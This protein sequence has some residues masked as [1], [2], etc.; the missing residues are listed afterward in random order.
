[1]DQSKVYTKDVV[2]NEKLGLH[3]CQFRSTLCRGKTKS[4]NLLVANVFCWWTICVGSCFHVIQ[5]FNRKSLIFIIKLWN[6]CSIA[7]CLQAKSIITQNLKRKEAESETNKW[8]ALTSFQLHYWMIYGFPWW[9]IS[10]ICSK[11]KQNGNPT[12]PIIFAKCWVRICKIYLLILFCIFPLAVY[13]FKHSIVHTKELRKQTNWFHDQ[14]CLKCIFLNCTHV[15][16]IVHVH[17]S[18]PYKTT[19]IWRKKIRPNNYPSFLWNCYRKHNI[20]FVWPNTCGYQLS[21][22]WDSW[23]W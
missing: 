19:C 22:K 7:T 16:N 5:I 9:C 12:D 14:I 20:S 1:M 6:S 11:V 13:F 15:Y 18:N 21:L 3:T 17:A 8:K 4:N 23:S 2:F 10:S